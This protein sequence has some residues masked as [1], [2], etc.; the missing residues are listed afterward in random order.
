[1]VDSGHMLVIGETQSGKTY[2]ANKLHQGFPAVSVF[3]NT[4]HVNVWGEKVSTTRDLAKTLARSRKINYLPSSDR[5]QARADL[6]ELVR[7]LFQHGAGASYRWCNLVVDEAQEFSRETSVGGQQ[8]SVRLVA[9]RGLG[10]YGI[11]LVVLTQY[12]P[13]LNTTTR[14]NCAT[15][16]VFRPGI[17]GLSFL[18]GSGQYP[19]EQ[20][21]GWTNQ[22]YHFA[23][24]NPALGW[25]YHVPV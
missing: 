2:Y 24:Y 3:F 17:E 18:R 7:F 9:T 23:S 11:R 1:M 16:V 15:R 14:T 22:K 13:A 4:N 6:D 20:I 8:D 25:R 5:E 12:P 21:V 19:H 10:A